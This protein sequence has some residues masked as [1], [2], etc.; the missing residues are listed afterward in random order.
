MIVNMSS[1]VQN[2]AVKLT[3]KTTAAGGYSGTTGRW[4]EG[5]QNTDV[6]FYGVIQ[7]TSPEDLEIMPEGERRTQMKTIWT[8]TLLKVDGNVNSTN[9]DI[10]KDSKNRL[11]RVVKLSD[12]SENGFYKAF[13][14][15]L[16]NG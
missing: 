1:V 13:A 4:I 6:I 9:S 10:I 16:P 2:F 15:Y 14:E 8:K 11:Y 3:L 7:P 5:G 12:R